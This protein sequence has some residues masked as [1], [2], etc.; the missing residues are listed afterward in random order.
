MMGHADSMSFEVVSA[1]RPYSLMM[2]T[3]LSINSK[4]IIRFDSGDA[5]EDSDE[6]KSVE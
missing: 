2:H 5:I 4:L 3:V 1:L 6:L